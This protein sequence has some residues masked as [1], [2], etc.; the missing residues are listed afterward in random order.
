MK[1]P[2]RELG[3]DGLLAHRDA[4]TLRLADEQL[5]LDQA[6]H[7]HLAHAELTQLLRR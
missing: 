5:A 7:D 6:I 2:E 1:A 3:V 4:E